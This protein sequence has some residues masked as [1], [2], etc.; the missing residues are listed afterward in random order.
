MTIAS[1]TNKLLYACNGIQT[2][3]PYTWRIWSANDLRVVIRESDGS[4]VLLAVNEHYTVSG[5]NDDE[6]GNVTLVGA[7]ADSPPATGKKLLV[8][9]N[10]DYVQ[11]THL[12][13]N[14]ATP[15]AVLE[16][17]LDRITALINQVREQVDR[18]VKV[19]ETEEN[20][21]FSAQDLRD[22][23]GDTAASTIAAQQAL[24]AAAQV[25]ANAAQVGLDREACDEDAAIAVEARSVTLAAATAAQGYAESA[26][27]NSAAPAWA[28]GT[29]YSFPD[30]VAY[31]DGCTYRCTGVEVIGTPPPESA[32]WVQLTTR[33]TDFFELDDDGGMMPATVPGYSVEFDLDSNGDIQPR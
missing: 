7:Y 24:A 18:A 19:A 13:E 28:A 10:L 6:G 23:V 33:R 2:V 5:V 3:F 26:A 17:A 29:L 31:T 20:P 1:S 8:K 12:V 30:I 21:V 9:L 16:T 32:Q 15:A 4:E 11:E 22:A 14:A 25:A 27:A